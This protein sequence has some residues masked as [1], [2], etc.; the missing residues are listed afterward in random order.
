MSETGSESRETEAWRGRLAGESL[1]A[2]LRRIFHDRRTGRLTLSRE[3][4]TLRLFF[5]SG[6]LRTA[7][8]SAIVR[9]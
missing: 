2:I 4:E 8:S 9:R 7:T 1:P 5:D 6:E 3:A